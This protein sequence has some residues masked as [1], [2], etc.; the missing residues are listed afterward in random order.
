[1]LILFWVRKFLILFKIIIKFQIFS[2]SLEAAKR[3]LDENNLLAIVR[4]H[5]AQLDGFKIFIK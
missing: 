4:A 3:F 5:E 2:I 1:M